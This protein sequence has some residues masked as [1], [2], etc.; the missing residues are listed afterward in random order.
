M[1]PILRGRHLELRPFSEDMISESYLKWL[2]EPIVNYY[3][4]RRNAPVQSVD[5]VLGYLR[6]LG[7]NEGI[8]AIYDAASGHVGNIGYGPIEVEHSRSQLGIMVGEHKMWGKGIGTEAVY[9][10]SKFLIQEKKVHRVEAG[11]ANPAFTRITQKLGWRIE[12]VERDRFHLDGKYID[13]TLLGLLDHEFV[14]RPELE[15]E[16]AA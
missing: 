13:E 12:G 10:V 6:S 3:S 11:T 7:P 5:D 14:V 9:L 2:S 15:P 16:G 1:D 8:F 4:R